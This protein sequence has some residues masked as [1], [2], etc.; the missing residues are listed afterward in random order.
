MPRRDFTR[1]RDKFARDNGLPFGRLLSREYVLSVLE[2]EGLQFRSRVFCPLVVLWAWLSQC[3]SQDKSLNEVVSRVLAH[4][5]TTG[6]PICSASSAAYSKARSRFPEGAMIRMAKEIGRKVHESASDSWDWRG[7]R[8]YLAD[9]TGFTMQDTPENQLAY[10]QNS[11]CKQGLGFPVMRAVGLIS[12]ATGAVVDLAFDRETGKGT[13]ESSLLRSMMGTLQR[14]DVLVA[15][16]YYPSYFTIA[17]MHARGVDIVSVSH[18]ARII[19]FNEGIVLGDKDHVAIWRKPQRPSWMSVEVY[20][21]MPETLMMREFVIDIEDRKGGKAKAIVV[22]S[23]TD[24]TIPQDE[25]SDLY[26]RRWNCELDIRSIKHSLQMDVLRC[27]TP[28]MVRKEI[29]CH[30]L[31]WNLLRGVMVESAK[32][33]DALPRQLSVKGTMQAVESFTPAMMAIDGNDALYNAML[34]TVSAHRVGNRPGRLE[35]RFKKRRPA[36]SSYMNHP[37]NDY[38]RRLASESLS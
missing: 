16:R 22:S 26:W 14:G 23:I 20:A 11:S 30:M 31:A 3:L 5:V 7:R 37:R 24:A 18:H 9:G 29:W 1:V 15:D 28:A 35:P 19:D 33:N 25:L 34:D 4:R 6:L 32:R 17:M 12:L 8:V 13:G 2:G 38:R 36:W 21:S 27:K 10:P